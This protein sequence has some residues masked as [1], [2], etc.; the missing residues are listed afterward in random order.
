MIERC[1]HCG[2]TTSARWENL[3]TGLVRILTKAIQAVYEKKDNRFHWH[4]DLALTNNESHNLQKLRF[5]GLIAHADK[6]HPKSG[7][8]L[9]TARGGAFLRGEIPVPKKVLIFRNEVKDHSAE[10][11]YIGAFRHQ[12]PEFQERYAYVPFLM[13]QQ[14]VEQ[15]NLF[16]AA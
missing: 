9:I 10:L 2:A 11:V 15:P 1:P 3:S 8:W 14:K 12:I 13:P 16:I 6:E 7:E 4:R 5:H